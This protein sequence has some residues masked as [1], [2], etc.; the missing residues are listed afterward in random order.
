MDSYYVTIPKTKRYTL[1]KRCDQVALSLLEG[2]IGVGFDSG[3]KQIERLQKISVDL[4]LLK[5]LI[6]LAKD[7]RCLDK[8][9]YLEVE[10]QL[11]EIGKMV[12]GWIKS[13]SH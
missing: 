4:D 1:W 6:R 3:A 13:A 12:G 7:T 8:K 5:V 9:Q 2:V 10:S 11:Q